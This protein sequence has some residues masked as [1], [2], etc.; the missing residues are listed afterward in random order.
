MPIASYIGWAGATTGTLT[1]IAQV[2]RVRRVGTDGVNA[3]TWALFLFMS[4]FW[5]A[6]GIASRSPE[7]VVASLVGLPFLVDLLARLTVADRRQGLARGA[8]AV[9]V[10]AWLPTA[11]LGWDGGLLGIGVLVV[12]TRAPQFTQVVRA[13]H[14]DGVSVT[15]WLLGSCSVAMWLG[16]YVGTGRAAAAVTMGAALVANLSIVA[17]TVIR[18]RGRRAVSPSTLVPLS[19]AS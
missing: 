7:I 12:A 1:T 17:M 3:T 5:L 10:A 4:G 2:V 15:S 8:A 13:H 19:V 6:Y 18:H 9:V 14:A 16:F 11:L